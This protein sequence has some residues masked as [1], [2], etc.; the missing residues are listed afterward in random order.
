MVA[1]VLAAGTLTCTRDDP[2]VAPIGAVTLFPVNPSIVSQS[3]TVAPPGAVT[4]NRM[5]TSIWTLAQADLIIDGRTFDLL[6]K[7]PN[8]MPLCGAIDGPTTATLTVGDC[9]EFIVIEMSTISDLTTL[10]DR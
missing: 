7:D 5:Q 2:V 6:F 8:S 4:G 10:V 1:L 3:V 9:V